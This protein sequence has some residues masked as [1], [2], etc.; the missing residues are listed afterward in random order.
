[1]PERSR[2]NQKVAPIYDHKHYLT[3]EFF[4]VKKDYLEKKYCGALK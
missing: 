4:R 2:F 1:M 3:Y